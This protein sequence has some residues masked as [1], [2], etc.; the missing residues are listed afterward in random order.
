MNIVVFITCLSLL[1][2]ATSLSLLTS[3]T[4]KE[5]RDKTDTKIDER[6]LSSNRSKGM[7]LSHNITRVS[8]LA[9]VDVLAL[10]LMFGFFFGIT[11]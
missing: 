8:V 6:H 3:E 7:T 10:F 11:N 4:G 1:H 5:P 2:T 9:R